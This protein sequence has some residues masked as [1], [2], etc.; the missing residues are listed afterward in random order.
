MEEYVLSHSYITELLLLLIISTL[1]LLCFFTLP[2]VASHKMSIFPSHID[3][4]EQAVKAPVSSCTLKGSAAQH[5][6]S[7]SAA[8]NLK[9]NSTGNVTGKHIT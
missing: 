3:L 9:F 5:H 6:L 2:P 4:E 1:N 7:E 8:A